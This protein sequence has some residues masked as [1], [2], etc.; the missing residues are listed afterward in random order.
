[1]TARIAIPTP[2]SFDPA[3][4]RANCSAYADAV[5]FVGGEPVEVA[6]SLSGAEVKQLLQDCH[7]IVLPGSP[8]D[9]EPASYGQSM[10][11]ATAPADVARERVDRALLEEAYRVR[12]PIFGI[13]FGVQ[14]LNVFRGG[15]LVQD[16]MVVPVNHSAGRSV[17]VAHTA[18]IAPGSLLSGIVDPEECSQADFPPRLPINS[19]HHQAVGIP[20]PGMTVSARCPQDGVVEAI[21]A[22]YKGAQAH[23][24]LGVQWHP[25]RSMDSSASSR[26][27]FVRVVEEAGRWRR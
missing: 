22:P 18:A 12:M 23:F 24:V 21:E 14:M 5:R 2:T 27:L 3:Y 7:G 16:L 1:M 19:S 26:A 25:E 4:N 6:L 13:C 17:A 10:Y 11:E 9:V 8:A 20:A 15:T